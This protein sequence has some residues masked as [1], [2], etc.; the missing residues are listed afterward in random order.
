MVMYW[1]L[2]TNL[3]VLLVFFFGAKFGHTAL[4]VG[5]CY[6]LYGVCLL[7]PLCVYCTR[8]WCGIP[9]H[10]LATGLLRILPD[11]AA[12]GVVVWMVGY[13]ALRTATPAPIVLM[14]QIVAGISTYA[15]C[16]RLGSAKELGAILGV[17]PLKIKSPASRLLRLSLPQA[18]A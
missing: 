16:F 3:A 17:L 7:A 5:T 8:R 1:G 15:L 14:L 12:M 18:L 10:G 9:L 2:T 13:M 4:A 6:M 11:V